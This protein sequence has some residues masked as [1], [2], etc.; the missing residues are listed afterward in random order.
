ML[1]YKM[2]ATLGNLAGMG[3]GIGRVKNPAHGHSDALKI[4]GGG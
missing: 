2:N 3:K 4:K 1:I